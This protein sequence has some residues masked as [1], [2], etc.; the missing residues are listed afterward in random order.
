MKNRFYDSTQS[1][2]ANESASTNSNYSTQRTPD[3]ELLFDGIN[4]V[5]LPVV[6]SGNG[7]QGPEDDSFAIRQ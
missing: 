2:G 6:E 5:A 4:T 3:S 1:T 7:A